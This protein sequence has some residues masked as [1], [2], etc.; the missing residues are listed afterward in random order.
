MRAIILINTLLVSVTTLSAQ[1]TDST[2][3]T[4]FF[5]K[6]YKYFEGSNEDKTL[7]KKIDFSIIGGP[8]YA[9]DV[10][11]GIG[12]VAA[13]LYRI[14]RSD[15]S[16]P[17]SSV[18]IFGDVATSGFY[19][20][21]IRG[22]TLIKSAKYRI[23]YT[24]YFHSMPTL[25]WGIG[26]DNGVNADP[27]EY[28]QLQNEIKSDFL[29]RVAK[30]TYIGATADFNYVAG[31]KFKDIS[32][33]NGE[34]ASYINVGVGLTAI[35]DSRDFIFNASRGFYVKLD[36]MFFPK[37]IGNK[38]ALTRTEIFTNYYHKLWKGAVMAYDV[39]AQVNF[40]DVPWTQL[41]IMGGSYRMRGYYI[42]RYRDNG[43]IEA[44]VELRQKV[45]RR[46]GVT[47]WV[48]GGNVFPSLD[49]F[50]VSHTLP[51]YGIG[52]RW[53]FKNRINVRLDYGFGRNQ[54]GFIFN[55]NEAF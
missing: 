4:S 8:H 49:K 50:N 24:V 7:T 29:Y 9:S 28:K 53:E 44:Q 2:R 19:S 27:T 13:G 40:G 10:G 41:A 6:V 32:Y 26:Y 1:Q 43:L 5:S 37:A 35:Y 52:Y 23:D 39:H 36:Q 18:S 42:G 12:L 11:F 22:N 20:L 17:P 38:G 33:L 15:L 31:K 48:G 30:N 46:N 47:A 34:D 14:D 54:S 51:N 55:I 45:Y 3:R 16:I 25:Y 21:G